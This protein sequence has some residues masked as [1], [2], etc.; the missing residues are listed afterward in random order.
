[1]TVD[2]FC[3]QWQFG[4]FSN[5]VNWPSCSYGKRPLNHRISVHHTRYKRI[6]F[7]CRRLDCSEVRFH[8]WHISIESISAIS[9]IFL[10][11]IPDIC[12]GS[13]DIL[14][15]R[16]LRNSAVRHHF[17]DTH[18][19]IDISVSLTSFFMS[20][21]APNTIV[22][23]GICHSTS[24]YSLY[25]KTFLLSHFLSFVFNNIIRINLKTTGTCIFIFI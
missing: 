9:Y 15:Y 25:L 6:A 2:C 18:I 5:S 22:T 1:M 19:P 7:I 23:C 10:P 21:S 20:S 13:A 14:I 17:Q 16:R 11:N 12:R 4:G 8:S 24:R 3:L